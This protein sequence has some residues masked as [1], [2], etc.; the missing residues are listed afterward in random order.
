MLVRSRSRRLAVDRGGAQ[1]DH[2][3]QAGPARGLINRFQRAQDRLP[4]AGDRVHDDLA[5]VERGAERPPIEA[6]GDPAFNRK[7][8]GAAR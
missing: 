7:P 1:I 4:I 3:S 6:V 5:A 2:P 8:G